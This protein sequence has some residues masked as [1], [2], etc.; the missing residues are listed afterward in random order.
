M[1]VRDPLNRHQKAFLRKMRNAPDGLPQ[2]QWLQGVVL[3]WWLR[4]PRFKRR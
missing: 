2:D 4:K 3:R 1:S